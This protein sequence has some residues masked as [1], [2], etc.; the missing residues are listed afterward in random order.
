MKTTFEVNGVDLAALCSKSGYSTSRVPI[1]GKS[2]TTLD[3][4]THTRLLRWRNSVT[5]KLN[6]LTDA[7]LETFCAAVTAP[8]ATVKFYCAQLGKVVTNTMTVSTGGVQS[9]FL[10]QHLGARYWSGRAV[11]FTQV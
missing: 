8:R 10:L 7:D 2:V 1:Y 3:G 5:V 11:T 9:P 6:D 4:M